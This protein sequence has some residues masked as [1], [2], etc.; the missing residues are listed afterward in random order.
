MIFQFPS[1]QQRISHSSPLPGQR[2]HSPTEVQEINST[3]GYSCEGNQRVCIRNICILCDLIN[4]SIKE[5]HWDNYF[6]KEIITPIPKK[7]PV[8]KMNTL[9]PILALLSFNKVQEMILVKLIVSDM[10]AKLDPTQQGNR[11]RRSIT[12]YMV[13]M[14]HHI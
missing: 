14:L 3:R 10:T 6:K 1:S 8:L 13:R 11:K 2:V 5:G 9:R 4:S 7:Y 12:H